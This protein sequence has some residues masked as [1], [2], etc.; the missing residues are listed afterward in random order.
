MKNKI[1]IIDHFLATGGRRIKHPN[2]GRLLTDDGSLKQSRISQQFIIFLW[3]SLACA[4]RC[5]ELELFVDLKLLRPTAA[6][7]DYGQ[8]SNAFLRHTPIRWEK[9]FSS[10][11]SVNFHILTVIFRS[12]RTG[13]CSIVSA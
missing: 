7:L 4:I 13:L 5:K 8:H 3:G 6:A 2:T 11:L 1:N 10:K 12:R 9:W